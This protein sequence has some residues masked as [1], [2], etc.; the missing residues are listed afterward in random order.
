[1]EKVQN[2]LREWWGRGIR[3]RYQ[4]TDWVTHTFRERNKEADLCEGKAARENGWTPPA[5]RGKRFSISVASGMEALTTANAGVPLS[6]WPSR[7]YTD[8]SPST[9]YVV[10]YQ[11]IA[12]WMLKWVVAGCFLTNYNNG[13]KSAHAESVPLLNKSTI[14][15]GILVCVLPSALHFSLAC[16]ARGWTVTEPTTP[17]SFQRVVVARVCDALEVRVSVASRVRSYSCSRHNDCNHLY[18]ARA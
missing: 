8:G 13:W 9:K 11:R 4:S 16:A 1:M 12:P 17:V 5:L 15:I 14:E 18:L 7:Y 10:P 2:L 3:S 6:S